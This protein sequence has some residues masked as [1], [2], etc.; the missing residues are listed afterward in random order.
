MEQDED[1]DPHPGRRRGGH[2]RLRADG[3]VAG[4]AGDDGWALTFHRHPESQDG[5]SYRIKLT[6]HSERDRW[7]ARQIRSTLG[8]FF[9]RYKFGIC[10]IRSLAIAILLLALPQLAHAADITGVPKIRQGDLVM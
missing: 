10:M 7:P 4:A 8:T 9:D 6:G 2:L 5:S 1:A 3:P